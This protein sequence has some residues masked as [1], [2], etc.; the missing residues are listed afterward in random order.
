MINLIARMSEVQFESEMSYKHNDA[1]QGS[2]DSIEHDLMAIKQGTTYFSGTNSSEE[3][4]R[5]NKMSKLYQLAGLIYFERVLKRY[6]NNVRVA[7]WSGEAFDLL[8]ELVICERPFPLFFIACEAHTDT[9]RELILS[10]L[11]RTHERSNQRRLYAIQAMIESMWV[12]HDL[13]S[14]SNTE[15]RFYADTLNAV[16]S[17]NKLLPT[18]A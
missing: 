9:Q 10:T 4:N 3:V 15:G 18:L 1:D 6:P 13:I 7:R 11:E 16:M 17:S 2:L 8:R 5:G 12:Q 14:D